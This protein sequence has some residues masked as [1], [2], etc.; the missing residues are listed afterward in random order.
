MTARLLD[1]AQ[2][3][4]DIRAEVTSQVAR[5]RAQGIQPG[6]GVLIAGE[7]PGSEIYVR[8]KSIACEATGIAVAEQLRFGGSASTSELLEAV[9]HMSAA[10]D[11]DGI[12]VQ[13]P[14]LQAVDSTR[15]LAAVDPEKDGDG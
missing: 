11:V 2:I 10:D 4:R 3:A 1:G 6:L 5:L 8:N 13:L 12:L 9:A 14:L 7:D 15:V